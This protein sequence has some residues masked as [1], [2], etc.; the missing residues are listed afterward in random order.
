MNNVSYPWNPFQKVK[1]CDITNDEVVTVAGGD[2]FD[3]IPRYAPFHKLGFVIQDADSGKPLIPGSDY[4]F[5]LPF[6][7]LN[8]LKNVDVCG[9]IA[10][11]ANVKN[12]RYVIKQYSTLGQPFILS[13]IAH[14]ELVGN[15]MNSNRKGNWENVVNLPPEGFPG[16]KHAHPASKTEDYGDLIDALNESNIYLGNEVN[17]PTV[18]TQLVEH[19]EKAFRL[20]HPNASKAD[21]DLDLLRNYRPAEEPDLK[22]NSNELYMTLAMCRLL[23]EKLLKELGLYPDTDPTKPGEGEGG[24]KPDLDKQLTLGEALNLFLTQDALLAEIKL[25]GS[26]AQQTAR[27]NLGLKSGATANVLQGL[28]NSETDTVSQ[29]TIT[30][31]VMNMNYDTNSWLYFAQ[32]GELTLE[33]PFKFLNAML[34]LNGLCQPTSYSFT[35]VD[36]VVMLPVPLKKNDIVELVT[37]AP[38]VKSFFYTAKGGETVIECPY[39]LLNA[40][41]FIEGFE[42][43]DKYSFTYDTEKAYLAGPLVAGERCELVFDAPLTSQH[44]LFVDEQVAAVKKQMDE[45][46]R[47]L[48]DLRGIDFLSTD[49]GNVLGVGTDRNMYLSHEDLQYIESAEV[50]IKEIKG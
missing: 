30:E 23:F 12:K 35:V 31:V 15:M 19:L 36:G 8:Q 28:G 1:E 45:M 39:R 21:F 3:I 44:A 47:K 41:L 26:A 20:A 7:T 22:G 18:A 42:Q 4:E 34:F 9:G 10:I 27:D 25:R 13:D 49:D 33:P 16:D 14:A 37:D 24:D 6:E 29:K 17:N 43:P 48:D 32:G 2:K 38:I 50:T 40:K 46:A 5:I 11:L